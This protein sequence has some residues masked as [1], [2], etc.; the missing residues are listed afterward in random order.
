MDVSPATC[1]EARCDEV[2]VRRASSRCYR[3]WVAGWDSISVGRRCC[4]RRDVGRWTSVR[5]RASRRAV[6]VERRIGARGGWRVRSKLLKGGWR[7]RSKLLKGGWR[8]RSKL[9]KGGRW[10][11]SKLL[12]GGRWVRSKLLKGGRWAQ[13]PSATTLAIRRCDKHQVLASPAPSLRSDT[14]MRHFAAASGRG[15]MAHGRAA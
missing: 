11:R 15:P 9:L 7:V 3:R 1:V 2:E 10:V 4:A 13:H 5:R 8:V 12:K 14:T 6:P